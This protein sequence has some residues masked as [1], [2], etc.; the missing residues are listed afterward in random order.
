MPPPDAKGL[1]RYGTEVATPPRVA[2]RGVCAPFTT[3]ALFGTRLRSAVRGEVEL[4]IPIPSGRPG[5]LVMPWAAVM[6]AFSPTI[7]DR[8]LVADLG[9]SRIK[10]E[11]IAAA[12]LRVAGYGLAGRAARRAAETSVTAARRHDALVTAQ[13]E[14]RLQNGGDMLPLFLDTGLGGDAAPLAR[15]AGRILEFAQMLL[16][17]RQTCLSDEDRARAGLLAARATAVAE[18][19]SFLIATTRT[20]AADPAGL[21]AL[22]S[23][24]RE[25]V[26]A[27]AQRPQ[28]VMDGWDLIACLWRVAAG[29]AQ[30][31]VLRRIHDLAPPAAAEVLAWPGCAG[32]GG[33]PEPRRPQ[34]ALRTID[35]PLCEAALRDW[36]QPP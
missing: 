35:T 7:A 22:W 14:Q 9:A 1:D 11:T 10:P 31:Q 29:E 13:L 15:R 30:L 20:L 28:W 5:W 17:W 33:I 21:R 34:S 36:L 16:H 32:L 4:L 27:F 6:D 2:D 8:A 26:L 3:P 12:A 19:A 25:E 24:D 18:S 23:A